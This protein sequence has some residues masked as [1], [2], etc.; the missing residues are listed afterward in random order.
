[1]DFRNVAGTRNP[2][3]S[4]TSAKNVS[5]LQIHSISGFGLKTKPATRDPENSVTKD[6]N[7]QVRCRK[8]NQ[9]TSDSLRK[10]VLESKATVPG[11]NAM[12]AETALL[13]QI[14]CGAGSVE[15]ERTEQ[16]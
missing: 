3:D 7:A 15:L 6:T 5:L 12:R 4:A 11:K 16:C 13:L 8:R 9:K 2:E 1:M 10:R 14:D